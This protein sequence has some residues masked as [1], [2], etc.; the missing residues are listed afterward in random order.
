MAAET[1]C[2]PTIFFVPGAWHDPWVFD[3]VRSVLSAR[4]FETETSSLAS[5]GAVDPGVGLFHDVARIRS[6]LIS[7]IDEGKE[8][9]AIA[10]SYG[11]IVTSNAVE[12]LGIEQRAAQ[13]LSGGIVMILYLAAFAIPAGT[14][15][16]SHFGGTY[17]PE[18][19]VS[20]DRFF[21]VVQPLQ[22]LYAD[23]E[24][25]LAD[26]AIAALKPVPLQVVKDVSAYDPL[27]GKFEVGYIFTENDQAIPISAQEA[28]F[29][30]FPTG[31]FTANLSS[32]HSPFLSMPDALA[33]TIQ[34]AVKYVLAKR[35]LK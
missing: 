13:A 31:S 20:E 8:V 2:A 6:A 33:D 10:H 34:D 19:E 30:R 35:T 21:N 5:V 9:V 11:G 24:T 28:T 1:K 16:L 14:T 3:R 22:T 23:V 32:S 26:K 25:S 18:W 17:P 27:D 12:G 15:A 29:S 7:L 4:K